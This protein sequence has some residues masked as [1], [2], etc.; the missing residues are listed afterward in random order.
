MS[1]RWTLKKRL[2]SLELGINARFLR[3]HSLVLGMDFSAGWIAALDKSSTFD[4]RHVWFQIRIAQ[5]KRSRDPAFAPA[6]H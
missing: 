2:Q 3:S 1:P 6:Q 5:R 4:P